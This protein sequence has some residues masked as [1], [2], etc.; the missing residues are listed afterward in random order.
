MQQKSNQKLQLN[1]KVDWIITKNKHEPIIDKE[2]FDRVQ[3]IINSRQS[4]PIIKHSHL[5]K[6]IV[7]C[8]ECGCTL[9]YTKDKRR[10]Y[11]SSYACSTYRRYGLERCT[12]HYILY[13]DLIEIVLNHIKNVSKLYKYHSNKAYKY[14]S[15]N[16]EIDKNEDKFQKLLTGR[17][18]EIGII[19][20]K[21]Y[22]D[23]ALDR[24]G[25]EQYQNSVIDYN[26]ESKDL[27]N[28]IIQINN[29]KEARELLIKKIDIFI[30]KMSNLNTI[31]VL[32]QDVLDELIEKII[33]DSERKVFIY[34]KEIGIINL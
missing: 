7:R 33:I 24:I 8:L 32:S 23:Y 18:N 34:F 2:A 31:H 25:I 17:A 12:S 19:L 14:I 5:F 11:V 22:E 3:V 20:K 13:R 15:N 9:T 27:K 29:K 16:L 4:R 6:G 1:P 21:L 30:L 10:N 26:G 28:K